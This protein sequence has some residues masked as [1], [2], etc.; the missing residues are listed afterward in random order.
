MAPHGGPPHGCSEE[1]QWS[2]D[3]ER[4][5]KDEVEADEEGEHA[6]G[7]FLPQMLALAMR[8]ER[9]D[10]SYRGTKLIRS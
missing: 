5:G 1:S 4:R 10:Q 8:E 9:R 6:N 3:E 2:D 7:F